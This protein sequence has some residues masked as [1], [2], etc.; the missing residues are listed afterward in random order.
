MKLDIKEKLD[1]VKFVNKTAPGL[2]GV[3][4]KQLIFGVIE[5]LGNDNLIIRAASM[6]F[7]FF[8]AIFPTI[9]FFFSLIPYLPI[10]NFT[11]VLMGYLSEILPKGAFEMLESTIT[12][13]INVQRSGVTSLNFL[14]A[15][16]FSSTGVTSMLIAFDKSNEKYKKRSFIKRQMVS[17]KLVS[18]ISLMF[19]VSITLVVMG[20]KTIRAIL[21]YFNLFNVYTYY[22]IVVLKYLLVS[23]AF[24][25]VVAMIYYYGPAVK[26]KFKYFSAGAIFTTIALILLSNALKIYFSLLSN[27]NHLY[28]SLGIVIVSLLFV[29]LNCIILLLGF[30][31]NNSILI[32]KDDVKTTKS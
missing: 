16:I 25:N 7:F 9:I 27:F 11:P 8:L 13:I 15:F 23:F 4:F 2:E 22:I 20:G 26:E 10:D 29:Y 1:K 3:S 14:M 5:E 12:D 18:L 30:E 28:G 19:L 31:I 6:S 17:L 32:K 24:F 21:T